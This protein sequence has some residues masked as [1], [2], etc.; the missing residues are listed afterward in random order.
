VT[1]PTQP[2]LKAQFAVIPDANGRHEIGVN[3]NSGGALSASFVLP[4][5]TAEQF[6][7]QFAAGLTQ[8]ARDARRAD[9]GIVVPAPN[10]PHT[11]DLGGGLHV[12]R[13]P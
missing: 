2:H 7:G 6:A 12:G 8:A 11:L 9:L 10:L 13:R 4:P 3:I 1:S 5:D